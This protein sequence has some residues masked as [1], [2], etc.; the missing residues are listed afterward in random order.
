MQLINRLMISLAMGNNILSVSAAVAV[1]TEPGD[2]QIKIK[3]E[4][5]IPQLGYNIHFEITI[6]QRSRE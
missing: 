4:E 1:N 6:V 3:L 2:K 5:M